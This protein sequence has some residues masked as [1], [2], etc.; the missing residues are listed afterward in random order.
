VTEPWSS[1]WA[2]ACLAGFG[3]AGAVLLWGSVRLRSGALGLALVALVIWPVVGDWIRVWA[4][5]R[6]RELSE[7]QGG[8][9][10]L[11]GM[12][13]GELV[14]RVNAGVVLVQVLLA[15][16]TA[17]ALYRTVKTRGAT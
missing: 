16:A 13:P 2:Y 1:I 11:W 17:V 3:L 5:G 14:S 4:R 6:A 12:S 9:Q 7:P 10:E 15:V 8:I